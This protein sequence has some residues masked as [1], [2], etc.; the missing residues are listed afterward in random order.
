MFF[1]FCRDIFSLFLFSSFIDK[2]FLI[3][4]DIQVVSFI[5]FMV[6]YIS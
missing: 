1:E 5:G 4:V 2:Y 3:L 6:I